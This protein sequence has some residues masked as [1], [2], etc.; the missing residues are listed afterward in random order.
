MVEH[1]MSIIETYSKRRK[2]LQGKV[3]DVFTYDEIPDGLRIQI[4]HIWKQ[5]FGEERRDYMGQNPIYPELEQNLAAEFGLFSLGNKA[6]GTAHSIVEY[7]MRQADTEQALDMIEMSFQ[8][9]IHANRQYRW[10]DGWGQRISGDEAAEDLNKRFLE[11]GVG[12]TFIGD[13]SPQLIRKDNEHLHSETVLPALRLLHEE[14]FS[15]ANAEYRKAH[16]H[17]R[18]GLQKECLNEC[19][20]AFESTMK[21]ICTKRKWQFK[22]SDTASSLIETCLK[23]SLLPSFMQTHLGTV[24]SALESAI[25][26]VRNKLGGHGQGVQPKDVPAYYADYLLHETATTIVFLIDAYKAL[27]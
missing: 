2:R 9:S 27:S 7:F 13:E 22:E 5:S 4:C 15:G 23:N 8:F 18:Q 3:L 24:K 6:E 21:T 26:T 11:H 12:Y 19:L 25:P 14:G 10:K 1:A 16:E 17:Y 20:K